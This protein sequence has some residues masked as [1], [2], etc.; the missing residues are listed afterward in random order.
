MF[1]LQTNYNLQLYSF[2]ISKKNKNNTINGLQLFTIT[3]S[4]AKP[5]SISAFR[6]KHQFNSSINNSLNSR[7]LLFAIIDS[8]MDRLVYTGLPTARHKWRSNETGSR[9][10][11]AETIL[12]TFIGQSKLKMKSVFLISDFS[13][14]V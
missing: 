10:C 6:E 8:N 13:I 11:S 9:L 14:I 5:F 12:V 1:H 7:L 2:Q 3:S 4:L